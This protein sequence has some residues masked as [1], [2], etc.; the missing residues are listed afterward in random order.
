[1]K[2]RRIKN[3]S[4][5]AQKLRD[6]IR[7]RK[8]MPL[9]MT[10]TIGI[11]VFAM[12]FLGVFNYGRYLYTSGQTQHFVPVLK[13][14]SRLDFSFVKKY[15]Q[16]QMAEIDDIQI[17][18]KFKHL[19]RIQYL[20]EKAMQEKYIN[21][22]FKEED[23][24]AKLT[25]NG[26]TYNVKI[27]LTGM[28]SRTHVG[29]PNKWSFE[30]KVKGG[31]TIAG[32]KRFA[33]LVPTARGYLTDW[34]AFRLQEEMGL[35]GMR[36]DFVNVSINGKYS[37]VFYMEERFDKYLVENNRL[38]EG[39]IFKL[40]K[41]VDPYQEGS[42]MASGSTRDQLLLIRR[43]WQDVTAGDLP[44]ENFFDMEK[45]AKLFVIT[46]LMNNR[47]PLNKINLRFYFNPVTG[48][49]EP[50]A[51]EFEDLNKRE[52]GSMKMFIEEP[53]INTRHYW[54]E[55]EVIIGMIARNETFQ[56]HY[57][58]QANIVARREFLDNF[59]ARNEGALNA[60][61]HKVYLTLP[62]YK[63]PGEELYANQAYMRAVLNPEKQEL[64]ARFYR[65]E[66]GQ[67]SVQLENQQALPLEVAYLSAGGAFFY[68][69]EPVVIDSRARA[70]SE[71]IHLSR[72]NIPENLAWTD[73]LMPDLKA[74]YNFLGLEPGE[75]AVAVLPAAETYAL[76]PPA[77]L[78]GKTANYASFPFIRELEGG[79][80][81]SIPAGTW[82]L[83]EDLVIPA[84]KRLRLEA[85]ARI[86]LVEGARIISYAP[87]FSRGREEAPV[88]IRSSDATG[89]G[90]AVIGAGER[91]S[92][93]YTHFEQLS[94]PEAEGRQWGGAVTFYE[95]PVTFHAC[96]FTGNQQGDGYLSI[97]RAAFSLE[98]SR[99]A[100]VHADAFEAYYSSGT[101][102]NVTFQNVGKAGIS[103][104]GAEV[105]L[106]DIYMGRVGGDGIRADENA[107][108]TA[109]WIDIRGA[110]TGVSSGNR[111]KIALSDAQLLE[112]R[113][114]IRLEQ[115]QGGYQEA[116]ASLS[117]VAIQGTETPYAV[118]KNS[119][120]VVDGK[121]VGE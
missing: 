45:M 98:K 31:E 46:D 38:R 103:L 43:M 107:E 101:A 70:G 23:F 53:D 41:H 5:F 15:A 121:V 82:T 117:K 3:D 18:I 12:C 92:L 33:M 66:D 106:S 81:L 28:V 75:K 73:D 79:T 94:S 26:K 112:N 110:A 85:G 76:S 30:V 108:V 84:G 67:V 74:H 96:S 77:A 44:A 51:R 100:D 65:K 89:Q 11:A 19:L 90:L 47:H 119:R 50:I 88:V 57:I 25:Y 52:P 99:F 27:A 13:D 37:G 42:L 87:A 16:G 1:M 21:P 4:R 61:L 36:V 86:D 64:L 8:R 29:N 111:S 32:M 105:E 7:A 68:P 58:R 80:V 104:T 95:S 116:Y 24:P 120:L 78:T 62:F 93:S 49:A 91:S 40:D 2:V 56:R 22:A 115:E 60:A 34:L 63:F 114:G 109:R 20:R 55:Q 54:L 118:G 113:T 83:D 6:V 10:G 14:L 59:F 102:R 39:I 35:I 9:W 97:I 48:L 71:A 69:E 17:D 72:F